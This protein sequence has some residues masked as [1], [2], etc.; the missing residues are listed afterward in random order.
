M[1]ASAIQHVGQCR[2][3][4]YP[5]DLFDRITDLLADMV[6]EDLQRYPQLSSGSSIDRSYGQEN[7]AVLSG[8]SGE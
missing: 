4:R 2:G 8:E 7:T 1:S 3:N 6:L 5:L